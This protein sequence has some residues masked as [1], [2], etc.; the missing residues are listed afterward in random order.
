MQITEKTTEGLKREY[1]VVIA[2]AAIEQRMTTRLTEVGQQVNL[3][4]FRPGKAPMNLLRKRFGQSVMGEVLDQTINESAQSVLTEKAS[5]PALQPKIELINFAEG[6]DLEF[7]VKVEVLPDITPPDF[8]QVA[9]EKWVA[10]VEDA[11]FDKALQQL[12]DSN[13]STKVITEDRKA[14]KG[15]VVVIDYVGKLDGEVFEGGTAFDAY[16]ELGS[17]QF[18][19]GFEDQLIGVKSGDSA[20]LNITFPTDYGAKNLAGKAVVFNVNVKEIREAVAATLDDEFAKRMGEENAEK[21]KSRTRD[22]MQGSY[23]R[24]SR[25]RLKRNLLDKLSELGAFPVPEGMVDAEFN[26]IWAQIE[27]A[28]SSGQLDPEDANKSD[29]ELRTEYRKIAER[30]VRLGLLLSDVGQKNNIAVTPE[31]LGQAVA[32]QASRFPGQEQA[33][34]NYYKS[35]PEALEQLRAPAFED[36]VVDFILARAKITEKAVTIDELQKDPETPVALA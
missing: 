7:A 11:E 21:L 9:L 15:D 34:V 2:A 26:A 18:I 14:V 19:P 24:L 28:K 5:K 23:D 31:E 33:V 3:P 10:K 35:T 8:G 4:G 16:L 30:R 22:V 25:L 17:G 12:L 36:K 27:Q 32:A 29:D 13:R 1:N 20:V 6:K